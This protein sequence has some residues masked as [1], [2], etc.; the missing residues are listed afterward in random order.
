MEEHGGE[1]NKICEE[2]G[3]KW[4]DDV[5]VAI[6][7]DSGSKREK[8]CRICHFSDDESSGESQLMTLGCDCR[9]ELG[10]S[11]PNC[12]ALWFS[13]KGNGVCEICGK[14]AKNINLSNSEA[15]ENA[16]LR[17]EMNEIRMVIEAIDSSNE[18]SRRCKM[19]FCNFLL[20]CLLLAFLLPWFF[21]GIDML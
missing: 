2:G 21:R 16:M 9:G 3:K 20:A 4:N 18:S 6:K 5:L 10:V 14:S 7:E 17:M 12:A 11:H 1:E 8:L 13:R 15:V 19:S